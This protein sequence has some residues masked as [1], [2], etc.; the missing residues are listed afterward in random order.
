MHSFTLPT[1]YARLGIERVAIVELTPVSHVDLMTRSVAHASS[2]ASA[3]G[4][5]PFRFA[6]GQEVLHAFPRVPALPA[7][8]WLEAHGI[9]F[10]VTPDKL[11]GHGVETWIQGGSP[12]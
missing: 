6:R 7:R 12:V 10:T 2:L 5:R 1:D 11:L 9:P 8:Q 3:V 4:I